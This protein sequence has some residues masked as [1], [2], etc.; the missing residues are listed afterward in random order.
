M[1]HI[2]QLNSKKASFP[3]SDKILAIAEVYGESN[4]GQ[5]CYRRLMGAMLRA[6]E[7]ALDRCIT[8]STLHYIVKSNFLS[9][10]LQYAKR[11]FRTFV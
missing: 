4:E 7:Y 10:G 6:E 8:G 1:L 11:D 9:F 5:L 2:K 3:R